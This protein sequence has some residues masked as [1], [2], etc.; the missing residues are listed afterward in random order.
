MSTN[1]L[2]GTNEFI[3]YLI[4]SKNF[5]DIFFSLFDVSPLNLHVHLSRSKFLTTVIWLT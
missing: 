3:F 1:K 2:C 4:V 5:S